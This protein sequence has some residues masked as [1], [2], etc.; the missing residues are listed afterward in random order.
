MTSI[1]VIIPFYQ[2]RAGVLSASIDSVL[3]QSSL[4]QVTL[5]VVDDGAPVDPE[6]ELAR[7]RD[8]LGPGQVV[9]HRKTN[10]G[11]GSARNYALDRL[12][13][14]AAVAF[15]DSDDAWHSAHLAN[16]RTALAQDADFYF[17]DHTPLGA[18]TTRFAETGFLGAA[19]IEAGQPGVQEFRGDLA[20]L[21]LHNSPIGTSTVAFRVAR[22]PRL[23]FQPD[24]RAGE[25]TLFWL[26][27]TQRARRIF[28]S[29]ED[30]VTYGRG[31]NIFAGC[32]WGTRPDLM[33]LRHSAAFHMHVSRHVP[34][35][36]D[37]RRR[38]ASWLRHLDRS[39]LLSLAAALRHREPG[40]LGE[41]AAYARMRPQAVL[42]LGSA[43]REAMGMLARRHRIGD[44][45][46]G[47]SRDA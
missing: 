23:R 43:A 2:K 3:A 33:R 27:A 42:Q 13:D 36:E 17:A 28:F 19:A 39:F 45:P 47:Q 40:C 32:E 16:I 30:C 22:M 41:L 35:R 9:L 37:Q 5:H 18:A 29:A 24:W 10:G 34:L 1:A 12:A 11:P 44:P 6:P 38:N 4:D 26:E 7:A 46:A 20:D 25:D 21:I 31:V 8:R 15:L 14:V